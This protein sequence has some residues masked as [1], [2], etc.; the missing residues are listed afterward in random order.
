MKNEPKTNPISEK[1]K[2]N[3]NFYSTKDY[4][5]KPPCRVQKNKANSNPI[6][7]RYA[8]RN[9]RYEIQTQTKP[10]LSIV[11]WANFRG[12]KCYN[13]ILKGSTIMKKGNTQCEA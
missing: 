12:K 13:P 8:I 9:T 10:V 5:N 7:A 3:L 2:M 11:E 4:E 6:P 1:P